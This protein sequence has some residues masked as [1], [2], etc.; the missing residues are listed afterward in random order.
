M[1]R[2]QYVFRRS[3]KYYFR[4]QVPKD[5]TEKV[6]S[7]EIRRSLHTTDRCEALTRVYRLAAETRTWFSELRADLTKTS[8][9]FIK[10]S[11]FI[12]GTEN[13]EPGQSAKNMY[14]CEHIAAMGRAHFERR[15][16]RDLSVRRALAK[17]REQVSTDRLRMALEAYQTR[18]TECLTLADYAP[19]EKYLKTAIREHDGGLRLDRDDAMLIGI[20]ILRAEAAAL[21]VI[22]FR[23]EGDYWSEPTDPLFGFSIQGT[24]QNTSMRSPPS[25][26]VPGTESKSVTNKEVLVHHSSS[27]NLDPK[28][29]LTLSEVLPDCLKA[30]KIEEG[31]KNKYRVAA[32]MFDRLMGAKKLADITSDDIKTYR[33][34]LLETPRNYKK[35]FKT[36]NPL[37]AIAKNQN[38]DAPTISPRTVSAGYLTYVRQIL[39]WAYEQDIIPLN[40]AEVISVKNT[41][42]KSGAEDRLPFS[43]AD[44]RAIFSQPL[45]AQ[46]RGGERLFQ[47]GKVMVRDHRFWVPLLMLFTGARPGEL[48]Q[49]RTTDIIRKYNWPCLEISDTK[50]DEGDRRV[51]TRNARRTIPLLSTPD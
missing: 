47:T 38:G 34:R 4:V 33:N 46:C 51:K 50:D 35:L 14:V 16:S 10:I 25:V 32:D 36:D 24:Q 3:S 43:G 19:V 20:T 22:A 27:V 28:A 17:R 48:G 41:M 1:A 42:S 37:T 6:G 11:P 9:G 39:D 21:Q 23:W 31:T 8:H 15:V 29:A 26:S 49:L 12:S 18:I 2:A 30:K 5:L 44:L 45:Y 40:P 7:A 13:L